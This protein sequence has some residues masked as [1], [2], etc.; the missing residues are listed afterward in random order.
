MY[1]VITRRQWF[2]SRTVVGAIVGSVA[3]G[4]LA[5]PA[6]A[7]RAYGAFNPFTELLTFELSDSRTAIRAA[8]LRAQ[9]QCGGGWATWYGANFTI[10][11]RHPSP[12]VRDRSFLIRQRAPLGTLRY[13][14]WARWGSARSYET[15]SG[16]LTVS[17]IRA[18]SARVRLVI[19]S[20][21]H[22]DP[23]DTCALALTMRAQRQPRVLYVGVTDDDE[24]VWVRRQT[25]NSVEWISGYGT[26]CEPRGFM[27]NIHVNVAGM[28]SPRTFGW[29][30]LV[31]GFRH[32]DWRLSVHLGGTF[33]AL[34]AR[35]TLR[36][37]GSGGPEDAGRCDTGVRRWTAVST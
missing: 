11:R 9:P 36:I 1:T 21:P 30:Q 10:T 25:E 34:R 13:A 8:A 3:F 35:G 18:R 7:G 15:F 2:M 14:I 5:S 6:S 19:R 4:M 17:R 23:S 28:T 20:V 33:E 26:D 37:V 32:D 29:P 24:P 22:P 31:A 27:E 16:S 12:A